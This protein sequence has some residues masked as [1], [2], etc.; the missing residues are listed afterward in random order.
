[1]FLNVAVVAGLLRGSGAFFVRRGGARHSDGLWW[2][3]LEEYVAQLVQR[4]AWIEVS[5]AAS[6]LLLTLFRAR[7]RPSFRTRADPDERA[8]WGERLARKQGKVGWL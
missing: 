1:M 6:T 2:A 4:H 7:R 3:V 5:A 8:D